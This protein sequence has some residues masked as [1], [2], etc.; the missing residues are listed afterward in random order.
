MP[1]P[2]NTPGIDELIKLPAGEIALRYW[3]NAPETW[4]KHDASPVTEADL[5]VNDMLQKQL[6]KRVS[7]P[8]VVLL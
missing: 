5:A 6:L 4:D 8:V 7:S 3:Q 2:E 1:F